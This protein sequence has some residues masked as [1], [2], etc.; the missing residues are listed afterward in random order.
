M[1]PKTFAS[2]PKP[3]SD[4]IAADERRGLGHDTNP[5]T[6]RPTKQ[7]EPT[8]RLSIDM[9][10]SLHRRFKMACTKHGLTM[11]GEAI[12]LIERRAAELEGR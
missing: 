3:S 1:S 5:Q 2:A 8:K 6:R 10:A 12:E 9:P 11:V 7:E 4:A